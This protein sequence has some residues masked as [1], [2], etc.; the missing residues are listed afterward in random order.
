MCD[1]TRRFQVTFIKDFGAFKAGDTTQMTF[2]IAT[3]MVK[4]GEAEASQELIEYGKS[5]GVKFRKRNV[6]K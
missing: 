6:D 1:I 4:K 3:M 2:P 5:I